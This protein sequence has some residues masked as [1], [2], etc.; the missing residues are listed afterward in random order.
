MKKPMFSHYKIKQPGVTRYEVKVEHI[1][2]LYQALQPFTGITDFG[3]AVEIIIELPDA[4][5]GSE[6]D[7]DQEN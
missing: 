1:W 2:G 5:D 6:G 3:D 7:I 4:P